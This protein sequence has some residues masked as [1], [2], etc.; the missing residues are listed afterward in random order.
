MTYTLNPDLLEWMSEHNGLYGYDGLTTL[1]EVQLNAAL[2]KQH[3]VRLSSG[4]VPTDITGVLA[5]KDTDVIYHLAGYQM[6]APSLDIAS[7]K[8]FAIT[9]QLESGMLVRTTQSI[10]VEA[11]SQHD[12]LNPMVQTCNLPLA[13]VLSE[14][15]L[16]LDLLAA[17]DVRL[18]VSDNDTQRRYAGEFIQAHMK[19]HAQLNLPYVL[20]SMGQDRDDALAIKQI[21]QRVQASADNG[22]HDLLLWIATQQGK[23]GQLPSDVHVPGL[24]PAVNTVLASARLM[25]RISYGQGLT[26]LLEEGAFEEVR[27]SENMLVGLRATAGHLAV[28]NSRYTSVEFAFECEAFAVPAKD[29]LTV[30]F[31]NDTVDQAWVSQCTVDLRYTPLQGEGGNRFQATFQLDLAHRFNL[32]KASEK[33]EG[34]LQGQLYSPWTASAQVSVISGLPELPAGERAQI[35]EFI[36]HVVKRAIVSGLSKE[37]EASAPE[38]WL[39]GVQVGLDKGVFLQAADV[40]QG[41]D[42][43]MIAT[44]TAFCIEPATAVVAAGE[45]CDFRIVPSR[46]NVYWTCES[47]PVSADDVGYMEPE[48]G[49]TGTYQAALASSLMG[50]PSKVLIVARDEVTREPL[51]SALASTV[52]RAVTVNPMIH[53]CFQGGELTFTAGSRGGGNLVWTIQN[54]VGESGKLT[55]EEGGKRCRYEAAETLGKAY[56]LDEI[57]VEDVQSGDSSTVY[58]LVSKSASAAVVRL[59]EPPKEDGSLELVFN[60][61]GEPLED[62]EWTLP[63]DGQGTLVEGHYRPADTD[64][65]GF[66]LILAKAVEG[67]RTYEGHLILPWPLTGFSSLSE[68]LLAP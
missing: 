36:G 50:R 62:V 31:A 3:R 10:G 39:A 58:V 42:V 54:P 12:A 67:R 34:V 29:G 52:P 23:V 55:P 28:P 61:Y 19:E 68:Q 9:S 26:G 24:D 59:K 64:R 16:R 43:A 37:L 35:A 63:I 14:S 45:S 25:H 11:V 27:D 32:L 18:A 66:V 49:E 20:A 30:D 57:L 7:G 17:E 5:I 44:P 38:R 47:L 48:R 8:K 13:P 46:P 22:R 1:P 6:S 56:V 4:E 33:R 2:A 65:T 15:L 53:A 40:P 51:A 41:N 21:D 60:L